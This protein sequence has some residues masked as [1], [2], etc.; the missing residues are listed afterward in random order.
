MEDNRRRQWHREEKVRCS[1]S[2]DSLFAHPSA[3]RIAA[4]D[5]SHHCRA[6]YLKEQDRVNLCEEMRGIDRGQQ[7]RME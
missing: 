2:W 6:K 3:D 1:N 5:H 4:H 7:Q